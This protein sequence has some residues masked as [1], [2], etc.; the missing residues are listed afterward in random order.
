[1]TFNNDLLLH[2]IDKDVDYNTYI[3]ILSLLH[4]V[5]AAERV[6][7]VCGPKELSKLEKT[8]IQLNQLKKET[9]NV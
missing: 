4:V 6:V 2:L 1:M 8:L 9:T 3:Y 5:R 7:V